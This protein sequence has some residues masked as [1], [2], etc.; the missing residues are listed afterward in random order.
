MTAMI[1]YRQCQTRRI[2]RNVGVV[3]PLYL[4]NVRSAF[5]WDTFISELWTLFVLI[6]PRHDALGTFFFMPPRS[7]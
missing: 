6:T 5:P 4:V 2:W 3:A 7:L 1:Y